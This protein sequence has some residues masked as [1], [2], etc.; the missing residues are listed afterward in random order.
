MHLTIAPELGLGSNQVLFGGMIY[1]LSATSMTSSICT[2]YIAK[3][4]LQS[5]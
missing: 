3:A 4:H 5:A 1:Y 2:G